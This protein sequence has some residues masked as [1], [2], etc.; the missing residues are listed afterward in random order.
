M[1]K[2]GEGVGDWAGGGE[3]VLRVRDLGFLNAVEITT[4]ERP[5]VIRWSRP[6]SWIR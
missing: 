2:G 6:V 3:V 4:S 5:F 1:S